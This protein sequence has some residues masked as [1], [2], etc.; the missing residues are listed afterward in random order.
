M[1]GNSGDGG[2]DHDSDDHNVDACVDVDVA[3]AAFIELVEGK[4]YRRLLFFMVGKKQDAA[5]EPESSHVEHFCETNYLS[6]LVHFLPVAV[7][8]RCRLWN[9]EWGGAKREV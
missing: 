5:H 4:T 8:V 2:D 3:L 7:Q 1:K 9:G 6:S